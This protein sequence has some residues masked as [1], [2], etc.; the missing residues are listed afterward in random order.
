MSALWIRYASNT[1]Y[2]VTIPNGT[3]ITYLISFVYNIIHDPETSTVKLAPSHGRYISTHSR[4]LEGGDEWSSH[5][6]ADLLPGSGPPVTFDRRLAL[7]ARGFMLM[8]SV[9]SVLSNSHLSWS[10]VCAIQSLKANEGANS[11]ECN[12]NVSAFQADW[13]Q[14]RLCTKG[15]SSRLQSGSCSKSPT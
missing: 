5:T 8:L 1:N 9:K 13:E 2:E 3:V 7:S 15:H 14:T 10:D 11:K 4:N 6:A 12:V